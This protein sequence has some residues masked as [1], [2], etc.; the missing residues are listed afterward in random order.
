MK[1]GN[2]FSESQLKKSKVHFVGVGGIGMCGLA[3]LLGDLGATVSG[4]DLSENGNTERLIA[5]GMSFFLGHQAQ[6][7]GNVDVVVA[8]SAVAKDNVELQEARRKGIPVIPRAEALAELMRLRRGIAVAGTHGKTTTTSMLASCLLSAG[9]N[10]TVVVGGRLAAINSTSSLGEG[11]WF[12]A[13]ADES[14]GSFHRLSPEIVIVT[15]IDNDHLDFYGSMEKLRLAYGQFANQIPFYGVAIVC[16]DDPGVRDMQALLHK[17][18]V[19][20]G[21]EGHNDYQIS[22]HGG[23]VFVHSRLHVERPSQLSLWQ[24]LVQGKLGGAHAKSTRGSNLGEKESL[25]PNVSIPPDLI[26]PDRLLARFRLPIP[27]EHNL[28]NATAALLAALFAGLDPELAAQ[29][30]QSFSGVDRRFQLRGEIA[31]VTV[32]DDYGHHPTEVA[33]TLAAL[34]ERYPASKRWVLFQ[35]HRYSRTQICW[36]QFLTCFADADEVILLDIYPAGEKPISEVTSAR[37][38]R[39]IRHP[40]VTFAE[41]RARALE[42]LQA[43]VRKADVVLTLGA[44]DIVKAGPELMEVLRARESSDNMAS[45]AAG[46]GR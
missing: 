21:F 16:G 27:G 9:W 25:A 2:H 24:R 20:Y 46:L 6:N 41:S 5:K 3:E 17:R 18:F 8:S 29:G 42:I 33:A 13:E 31:G 38:A 23:E 26:D 28:R 15:N 19:T 1:F 34:R 37:L 7:V 4:S 14:D 35:P 40:R 32:I 36:E 12:V 22:V 10:P 45:A 44:G 30:L 43:G 11:E 39:E